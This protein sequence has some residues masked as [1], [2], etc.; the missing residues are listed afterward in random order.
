MWKYRIVKPLSLAAAGSFLASKRATVAAKDE[1]ANASHIET[2]L[3][4]TKVAMDELNSS[5][6]ALCKLQYKSMESFKSAKDQ[7]SVQWALFK[8]MEEVCD[9]IQNIEVTLEASQNSAACLEE[10]EGIEA[11]QDRAEK[12]EV[13]KSKLSVLVDLRSDII[14]KDSLGSLDTDTF[15]SLELDNVVCSMFFYKNQLQKQIDELKNCGSDYIERHR[16]AN[17][18]AA[19]ALIK[20][21]YDEKLVELEV[22]LDQSIKDLYVEVREK[23]EEELA[24]KFLE[25]LKERIE[26]L[27][28]QLELQRLNFSEETEVKINEEVESIALKN[29]QLKLE[30]EKVDKKLVSAIESAKTE[31]VEVTQKFQP[32]SEMWL[33]ELSATQ[34]HVGLT[35]II[36]ELTQ[37]EDNLLNSP[38][39][40]IRIAPC[41]ASRLSGVISSD[42]L[43]EKLAQNESVYNPLSTD[44]KEAVQKLASLA[45]DKALI[46][47]ENN[48][49]IAEFISSFQSKLFRWSRPTEMTEYSRK[50]GLAEV[51]QVL[52]GFLH[53]L[54]N[55]DVT[56]AVKI[57]NQSSGELRRIF[58]PWLEESRNYLEI[59]QAVTVAKAILTSKV[60][61]V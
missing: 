50:S 49:L 13:F 33:N 55:D 12:L 21:E 57:M 61:S 56:S 16:N 42:E 22:K 41:L 36:R 44:A 54:Q 5:F 2:L 46:T 19:K 10:L 7:L 28:S 31:D 30:V 35:K 6:S 47:S 4:T 15:S 1:D 37:I 3:Q 51:D 39:T 29:L 23:F 45:K 40:S 32:T 24:D 11:L 43:S 20:S 38:S 18:P 8:Q 53:A 27:N 58:Q 26:C 34:K 60:L 14:P 25:N 48:G 52:S 59:L 17:L 9:L